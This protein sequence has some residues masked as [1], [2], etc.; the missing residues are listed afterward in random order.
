MEPADNTADTTAPNRTASGNSTVD[1]TETDRDQPSYVITVSREDVEQPDNGCRFEDLPEGA[2]EEIENAIGNLN[3]DSDDSGSHDVYERPR[4][5]DT[6]CYA[7]YI[8]YDG[9]Y[10]WT[11]ID[12]VGG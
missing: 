10:Y 8:E 5:L 12:A 7:A 9:G 1:D 3:A 2:Q 11:S 4:L 6:E